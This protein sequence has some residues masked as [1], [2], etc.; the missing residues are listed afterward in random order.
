MLWTNVFGITY[1]ENT[2]A[3]FYNVMIVTKLIMNQGRSQD[4]R[5]G[6][7]DYARAK[8]ARKF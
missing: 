7:A 8:R 2:S 5:E 3:H 6:G 4:F 1:V